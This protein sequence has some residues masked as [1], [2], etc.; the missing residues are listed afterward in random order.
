LVV[1]AL[2]EDSL[3][4]GV[5]CDQGNFL[6]I[7]ANDANK[8]KHFNTNA[9]AVY[10]F[11]RSE[12]QWSQEAYLKSSNSWADER[13]GA[14]LAIAGDGNTLAIGTPGEDLNLRGAVM[15]SSASSECQP[16]NTIPSSASSSSSTSSSSSS[17]S[18]SSISSLPVSSSSVSSA[19]FATNSGAVYVFVR[20]DGGWSEQAL[21]K[22]SNTRPEDL[23]G[24]SV[25]LSL[26][27]STLA[28]GAP[29]EVGKAVGINGDQALDYV[30]TLGNTNFRGY[31][32]AVYLFRRS[33]DTWTQ[34]AY[35]KPLHVNFLQKFGTGV[36]LSADGNRMA[37]S[38]P[39][40]LSKATGVNGNAADYELI[41]TPYAE[42]VRTTSTAYGAAYIFSYTDAGWQQDAYIKASNANE[43]DEFGHSLALSADGSKLAVGTINEA[44]LAKGINGDET[45]NSRR[46]TGAVYVYALG[47]NGWQQRSYVKPTNTRGGDRF[48]ADISLS[49]DGGVL[50]VGGYREPSAATGVNGDRNDASAPSAGAVH[51]Y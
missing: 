2:Y 43:F 46:D 23:F 26:D 35:V 17:S 45:D 7:D 8:V 31:V 33:A 38:A 18:S 11:S 6:Y 13:F 24:T 37:I 22:A 34:Q 42:L 9:G 50:A 16:A 27:G 12:G 48:G 25:A 3:A 51:L 29:Q 39:G 49:A 5:N 1:S 41:T 21:I 28:V 47:E 10:V 19:V 40:D 32:G 36:A 20:T 4:R 30:I 15:N 14:S 44:S